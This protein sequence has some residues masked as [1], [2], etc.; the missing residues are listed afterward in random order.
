MKKPRP[1]EF[2]RE[3]AKS[4]GTAT[5]NTRLPVPSPNPATNL[6]ITNIILRGASTLL[7]QNVEKKIARAS[8]EDDQR[9]SELLDGRT[10]ITSLALYGASRLAMRSPLGLGVVVGSLAAKTLYDRGK[11]RRA[12]LRHEPVGEIDDA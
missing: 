7:R 5:K 1:D 9:A 6:V 8:S 2:T 10:M 4:T 3:F 12:R 11:T